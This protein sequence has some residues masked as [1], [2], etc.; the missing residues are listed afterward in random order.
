MY[1]I[2]SPLYQ[3]DEMAEMIPMH[4]LERLEREW[5]LVE[6]DRDTKTPELRERTDATEHKRIKIGRVD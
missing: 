2:F 5:R 3:E 4:V 6:P 1:G